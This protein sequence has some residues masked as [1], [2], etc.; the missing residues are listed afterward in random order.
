MKKN[1]IK[2]LIIIA[3]IFIPYISNANLGDLD[4]G[5]GSKGMADF[6]DEE[7][8]EEKNKNEKEDNKESSNYVG[9]SSNNYLKSLKIENATISPEFNRQ[10][11]DYQV[12]L[13]DETTSEINILAEAEDERAKVTGTG[14]YKLKNGENDIQIVVTAENG[15]TK[16]E[17]KIK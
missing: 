12:T 10:Y 15:T 5:P 16:M 6:T 13:K 14:T 8:Q 17:Y 3:I 2:F 9:K 11:V 4:Y 7:A 1:I